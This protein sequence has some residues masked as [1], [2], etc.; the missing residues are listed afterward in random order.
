MNPRFQPF[1]ILVLLSECLANI[2]VAPRGWGAP[3]QRRGIAMTDIGQQTIEWLYSEQLQV[4]DEWAVRGPTGFTWWA[5]S[6]AQTVEIVGQEV[7]PDGRIGYLIGIRTEMVSELDL[8][9]QAL[10][11]VNTGPMRTAVM[12]G[13][14]YDPD[15]RCLSLCSLALVHDENASWMRILLSGAAAMQLTEALL[16]GPGLADQL[17]GEHAVTPHPH[18][19]LR[20]EPDPMAFAARIFVQEG[21]ELCR[22]V[23]T[24]FGDAVQQYMM[25]PPSLGASSGGS[26]LTVEFPYGEGSSLCQ[27]NGDQPHPIYGQGLLVVQRFPFPAGSEKEGAE[28]AM[29]LNRDDLTVYPAG[30]G[31]GSYLYADN[32]ICFV[33]F[34]PNSFHRQ[35]SLGNLYYSCA[36]RA[37][38]MSVRLLNEDWDENS[39][40]LERSGVAR[41]MRDKNK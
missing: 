25:Q 2:G 13:P 12:C 37:N 26:G 8:T 7:G 24:D 10:D 27:I 4:D 6:N 39:F 28:L 31:F 15:T 22:W 36:T 21:Q 17:G 40:S 18:Q 34:I 38:S 1:A 16:L 19:G 14:V 32:M 35:M 3:E 20:E 23:E 30:Y 11:D 5:Y 33:A 41:M 9:D 29:S